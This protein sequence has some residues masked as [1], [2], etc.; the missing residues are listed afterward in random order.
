MKFE[1]VC[2]YCGL[3]GDGALVQD[4]VTELKKS[5]AFVASICFLCYNDGKKPYCKMPTNVAKNDIAELTS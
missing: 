1:P 3:G 4:G 2:Y 5:Y